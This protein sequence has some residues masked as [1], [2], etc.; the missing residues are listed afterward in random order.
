M[1]KIDHVSK[2]YDGKKTFSVRDLNLEIRDGEIFGLLGPNGAGK[3]TTLNMLVGVLA[4]TE[5]SIQID[6]VDVAADPREAKRRLC[7]VSDSPDHLLRLRGSE[8]LRFIADIYGVPAAPSASPS[9]PRTTA[10]PPSWTT[11]SSPTRT[12]CAR[13]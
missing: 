6:G 12:A 4:P 3:S 2:S 10:W 5:G 7:F 8:Y 1:I 13:R 11:R 9:S